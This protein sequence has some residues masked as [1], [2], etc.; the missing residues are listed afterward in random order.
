MKISLSHSPLPIFK[1]VREFEKPNCKPRGA[2]MPTAGY[3]Y[4][5]VNNKAFNLLAIYNYKNHQTNLNRQN[6]PYLN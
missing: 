2:A 4:A 3:A 1:D 5:P 6:Q